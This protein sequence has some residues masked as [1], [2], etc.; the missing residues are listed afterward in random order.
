MVINEVETV[1]GEVEKVVS[2]VEL[3]CIRAEF[4]PSWKQ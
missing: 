4:H 1:V 3:R 2:I